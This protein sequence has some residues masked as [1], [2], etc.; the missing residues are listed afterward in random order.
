MASTMVERLAD[1]RKGPYEPVDWG[2][3][4]REARWWMNAIAD[5]LEGRGGMGPPEYIAAYRVVIAKIRTC[6]QEVS[7]G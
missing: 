6:A 4:E 1:K 5:E 2:S 7:D 3:H